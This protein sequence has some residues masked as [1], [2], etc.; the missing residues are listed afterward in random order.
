M[1]YPTGLVHAIKWAV[2][3]RYMTLETLG[4]VSQNPVVSLP[5]LA[6]RTW[7][8]SCRR[9]TVPTH[10]P[11]GHDR[12][13]RFRFKICLHRD[14]NVAELRPEW[15]LLGMTTR[16]TFILD[17]ISLAGISFIP[18]IAPAFGNLPQN[19]AATPV[20]ADFD[21]NGFFVAVAREAD[22]SVTLSELID[23][24][25]KARETFAMD[26]VEGILRFIDEAGLRRISFIDWHGTSTADGNIC[27]H[28]IEIDWIDG[29]LPPDLASAFCEC[30]GLLFCPRES[31]QTSPLCM[32]D[33]DPPFALVDDSF[34]DID[35]IPPKAGTA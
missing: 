10:H 22:G 11:E 29:V 32:E 26:N 23:N 6:R 31:E 4:S 2:S 12:N 3:R 35:V 5:A 24:R 27:V 25:L 21:I 9:S 8:R 18:K 1:I 20:D 28:E 33:Y 7:A 14:A 16:R 13:P 15:H 19:G 34:P 17:A 30:A